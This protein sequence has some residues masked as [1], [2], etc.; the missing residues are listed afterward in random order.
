V[1]LLTDPELT[2]VREGAPEHMLTLL[3]ALPDDESESKA[4]EAHV[5]AQQPAQVASFECQR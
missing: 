5:K 3:T 1:A 4:I 2:R